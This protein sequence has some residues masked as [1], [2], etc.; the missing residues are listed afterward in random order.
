MRRFIKNI[1]LFYIF[2]V[3]LGDIKD[4]GGDHIDLINFKRLYAL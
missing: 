3:V 1:S 2:K 4:D